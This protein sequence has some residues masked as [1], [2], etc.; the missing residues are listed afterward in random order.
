MVLTR[1]QKEASS[2]PTGEVPAPHDP[3]LVDVAIVQ[4][5]QLG[6]ANGSNLDHARQNSP[7]PH[8]VPPNGT[9]SRQGGPNQ[10]TVRKGA[11]LREGPTPSRNGEMSLSV[12]RETE[13]R[14][15]LQEVLAENEQLKKRLGKRPQEI[16]E[17]NP[18]YISSTNQA[19]IS[20]GPRLG[21]PP[22]T[23]SNLR[24]RSTIMR[25]LRGSSSS[26]KLA[27][28]NQTEENGNPSRY[29]PQGLNSNPSRYHPQ[30]LNG[31]PS[32]TVNKSRMEIHRDTILRRLGPT[33]IIHRDVAQLG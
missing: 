16:S 9:L 23:V 27:E 7:P 6:I 33:T 30:G 13:L 10:G 14:E 18:G 26:G 22:K 28:T 20:R 32:N 11:S 15:R 29:H 12:R 1:S 21:Y 2:R 25:R 8:V 17:R 24:R 5:G 31:N 3:A 19:P 4:Q